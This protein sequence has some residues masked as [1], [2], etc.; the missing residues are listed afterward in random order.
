MLTQIEIALGTAFL[1]HQ[2]LIKR[3]A[4]VMPG[5][6]EDARRHAYQCEVIA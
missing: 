3:R 2:Q 5:L 4:T 1:Y 6:V